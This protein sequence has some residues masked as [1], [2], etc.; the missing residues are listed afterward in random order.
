MQLHIKLVLHNRLE[1]L[2]YG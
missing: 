1:A 2:I